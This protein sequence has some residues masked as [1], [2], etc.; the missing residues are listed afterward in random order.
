MLLVE[1]RSKRAKTETL[2]LSEDDFSV[3]D[4]KYTLIK[5][6]EMP[7]L[8][9]IKVECCYLKEPVLV[10]RTFLP[11]TLSLD[12]PFIS[13]SLQLKKSNIYYSLPGN[14]KT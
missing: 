7:C 9:P 5:N 14:L 13:F 8:L 12:W 10:T 3:V 1:P 6:I 11:S 4:I 2:I